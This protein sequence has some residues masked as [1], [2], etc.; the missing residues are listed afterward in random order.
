MNAKEILTGAGYKLTRPRVLLLEAIGRMKGAFSAAD[1]LA[2]AGK[3]ADLD[4]VTIYRNLPV[5]EETGIICRADFS[6]EMARYMRADHGHSHHHHHVICRS[7]GK[8][9]PIE[10]CLAERLEKTLRRRGFTDIRHRLEFSAVCR[11]CA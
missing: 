1:L 8:V 9:E 2:E 6:D 5:L 3:T 11:S 4:L 7:C 10:E